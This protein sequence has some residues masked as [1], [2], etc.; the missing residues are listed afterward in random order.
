MDMT[1]TRLINRLDLAA[2]DEH[3]KTLHE[4]IEDADGKYEEITIEHEPIA[5]LQR[6][7]TRH[8]NVPDTALSHDSDETD[9]D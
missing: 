7:A 4:Q 5:L 6:I 3:L 8:R 9:E 1:D 2:Q